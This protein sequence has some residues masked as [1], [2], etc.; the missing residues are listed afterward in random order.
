MSLEQFI[1]LEIK[2]ASKI[3]SQQDSNQLER[4]LIDCLLEK[5]K[6]QK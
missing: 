1:Q 3:A 4:A 6:H 5:K 2:G